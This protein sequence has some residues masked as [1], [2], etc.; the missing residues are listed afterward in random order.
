MLSRIFNALT[1]ASV[2]FLA[3]L[4]LVALPTYSDSVF[5]ITNKTDERVF[6]VARWR[7]KELEVGEITPTS[8]YEYSVDDE[9]AIIFHVS[10]LGGANVESEPIYF[11]SGIRIIVMIT[12]NAVDVRYDHES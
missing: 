6:V 9:S 4:V 11:T 7:D 10:Y 2:L 12:D 8:T 3:I 1:I 5:E